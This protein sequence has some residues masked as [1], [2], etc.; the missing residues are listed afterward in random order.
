M[1]NLMIKDNQNNNKEKCLFA[2]EDV[3]HGYS[4]WIRQQWPIKNGTDVLQLDSDT[5]NIDPEKNEFILQR[6]SVDHNNTLI[7]L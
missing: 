5:K 3:L 1:I 6:I 7:M 4:V 2:S